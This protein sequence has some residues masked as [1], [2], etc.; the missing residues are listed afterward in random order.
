VKYYFFLNTFPL[1]FFSPK[2]IFHRQGGLQ[3]HVSW[4]GLRLL[5]R[6]CVGLLFY[7]SHLELLNVLTRDP[8]I[9]TIALG[10][11]NDVANPAQRINDYP[12]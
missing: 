1:F 12:T 9:C 8:T 11:A 6:T 7:Y 4:T 3:E 2:L 5:R 10:L